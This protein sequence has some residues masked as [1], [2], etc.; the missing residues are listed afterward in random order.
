MSFSS[1]ATYIANNG[2]PYYRKSLAL[3]NADCI[4]AIKP[5]GGFGATSYGGIERMVT[6]G[7]IWYAILVSNSTGMIYPYKIYTAEPVHT[8][9]FGL[10]VFDSSGGLT[11]TSS[12]RPLRI[13]SLHTFALGWEEGVSEAITGISDDYVW[14]SGNGIA[15]HISMFGFPP[16]YQTN[17]PMVRLETNL[18]RVGSNHLTR[19]YGGAS[20]GGSPVTIARLVT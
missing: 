6:A 7:G 5:T 8:G 13:K 12:M 20:A 4:V 10:Q 3:P 15:G 16:S 2:A 1:G 14:I 17:Y 9:N 11:F 18:L 19:T